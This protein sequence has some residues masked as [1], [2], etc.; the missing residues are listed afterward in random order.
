M[1]KVKLYHL[2][3]LD[4][5]P[6]KE[7]A[8]RWQQGTLRFIGADSYVLGT[9]DVEFSFEHVDA[10]FVLMFHGERLLLP[11]KHLLGSRKVQGMLY[12]VELVTPVVVMSLAKMNPSR[13][14]VVLRNDVVVDLT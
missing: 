8:V 13:Y 14:P 10:G 2:C 6:T 1:N 5:V 11:A 12:D 4:Q 7:T 9:K 3:G